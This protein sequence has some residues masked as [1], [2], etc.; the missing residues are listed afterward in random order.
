M[1]MAI[2]GNEFKSYSDINMTP[3]DRCHVGVADHF[4]YHNPESDPCGKRLTT[5]QATN[6]RARAPKSL[7]CR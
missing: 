7:I 1:A 6:R 5:L 4:H 3:F 2:N